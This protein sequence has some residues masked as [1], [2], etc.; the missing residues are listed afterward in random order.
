MCKCKNMTAINK[1]SVKGF[2]NIE[3]V[4]IDLQKVTS[5]LAPNNYGKSNLLTQLVLVMYLC[6]HRLSESK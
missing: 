2:R 5:L 4:E 3:S 1:I 6:V